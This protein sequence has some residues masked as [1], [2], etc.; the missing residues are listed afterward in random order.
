MANLDFASSTQTPLRSSS[1]ESAPS[2][3][4]AAT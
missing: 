2:P 3:E 4:P 1:C